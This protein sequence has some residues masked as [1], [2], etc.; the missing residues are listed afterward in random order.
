MGRIILLA[1][2]A[3]AGKTTLSR[4][5]KEGDPSRVIIHGD[6]FWSFLHPHTTVEKP[7]RLIMRSTCAAALPFA[8][9]GYDVFID[10]VTPPSFLEVFKKIAGSKEGISLYYFIIQPNVEICRTRAATRCE[11]RI[12][13]YEENMRLFESFSAMTSHRIGSDD[14]TTEELASIVLR[15]ISS[16]SS[17]YLIQ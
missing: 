10:F 17:S 8:K 1:G 11:G 12:E 13:D 3:G 9:E 14:S 6:H 7:F 15:E 2:P 16:P 4:F 5:L